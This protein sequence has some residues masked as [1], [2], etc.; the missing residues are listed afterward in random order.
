MQRTRVMFRSSNAA[1]VWIEPQEAE[2]EAVFGFAIPATLR[3][4]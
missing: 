3:D 1:L 4:L 2:G